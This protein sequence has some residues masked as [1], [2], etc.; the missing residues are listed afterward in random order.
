ML[1]QLGGVARFHDLALAHHQEAARQRGDDA[2]IVRDEEISQV[3]PFLQVAQQVDHLR[4]DQHVERAGRLVEH[5]EGRLQHDGARHR[6][7]LALAAGEFVRKAKAGRRVEADVDE[8]ADHAFVALAF[9]HIGMV[10][11]KSL[12]D[13]VGDRQPR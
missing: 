6:D 10:N 8:R 1:E 4:L 11:L 9:G 5:D 2:Q 13:D 7:A 12:L 3:A